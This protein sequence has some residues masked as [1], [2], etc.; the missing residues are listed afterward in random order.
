MTKRQCV[1]AG[2]C[3]ALGLTQVKPSHVVRETMVAT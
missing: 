2:E 1:A 3:L